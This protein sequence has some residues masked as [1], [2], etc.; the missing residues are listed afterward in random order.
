MVSNQIIPAAINYQKVL[1]D[2]VQGL[3]SFLKDV[4][5]VKAASTQLELI[6]EISER[7]STLKN[8]SEEMTEARKLANNLGN[9]KKQA[10]A[11]CDKVKPFFDIIRYNVDKLENI[12][13]DNVWPL[14]KY[15][16]MLFLR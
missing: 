3:K 15:R 16:E 5:F 14:P 2:S 9:S 4:E 8:A 13:D 7:I 11:Y 10:H 1:I 6:K 12:V